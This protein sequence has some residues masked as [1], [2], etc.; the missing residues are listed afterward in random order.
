[1]NL[2]R[3]ESKLFARE[4]AVMPVDQRNQVMELMLPW[5]AEG[6]RQE[7]ADIVLRQ[8]RRRLEALPEA[9]AG[10]I[11]E[12]PIEG[13]EDLADA[14]LDFTSLADLER[15]LDRRG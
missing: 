6:R 8:L 4:L 7:A 9:L 11:S 14:L 1:M 3:E 15:W 13:L 5:Q 2:N 10:R 12:F